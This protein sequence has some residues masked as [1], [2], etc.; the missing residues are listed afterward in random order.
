L[1]KKNFDVETFYGY[2]MN[3]LAQT[4]QGSKN[5]S[6]VKIRTLRA[7]KKYMTFNY[8]VLMSLHNHLKI[9]KGKTPNKT[10]EP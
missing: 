1:E 5:N 2:K 4:F 10:K 8:I 7:Y 3:A 9:E 6:P